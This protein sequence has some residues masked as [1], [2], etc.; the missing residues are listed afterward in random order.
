MFYHKYER[1]ERMIAYRSGQK[2]TVA[3]TNIETGSNCGPLIGLFDQVIVE[4]EAYDLS[5]VLCLF[6]TCVL[7]QAVKTYVHR[8]NF[9]ALR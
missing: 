6:C 7:S 4:F 8:V 3:Q 5:P 2:A 1:I 9:N